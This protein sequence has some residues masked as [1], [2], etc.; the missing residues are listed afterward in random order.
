MN[1]LIMK[2]KGSKN[3]KYVNFMSLGEGVLV[4]RGGHISHIVKMTITLK[5][6]FSAPSHRSDKLPVSIYW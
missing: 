3:T 2:K 5:F 4:L 6:F 1:K